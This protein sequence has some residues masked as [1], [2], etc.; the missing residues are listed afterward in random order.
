[1]KAQ[2]FLNQIEKIE[3]MIKN[4]AAD[5]E[6]WRSIAEGMTGQTYDEK[7]QSARNLHK[8]ETAIA[9]SVDLQNQDIAELTKKRKDIIKKIEALSVDEYDVLFLRYVKKQ[10][11][12]QIAYECKRSESWAKSM[13]AIAIQHLQIILDESEV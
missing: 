3:R 7:V 9:K 6:Y 11:F 1:M 8:M 4:K 13:H 2:D 5:V 12:K 10:S